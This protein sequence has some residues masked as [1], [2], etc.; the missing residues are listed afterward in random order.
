[1][2]TLGRNRKSTV[3]LTIAIAPAEHP[4]IT[5]PRSLAARIAAPSGESRRTESRCLGCPPER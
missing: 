5:A 4:A 2:R 1:M 3:R